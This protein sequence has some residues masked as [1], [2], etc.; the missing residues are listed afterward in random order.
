MSFVFYKKGK[1][2]TKAAFLWKIALWMNF[3][4]SDG[5]QMKKY[6]LKYCC[7]NIV[8]E[9]FLPFIVFQN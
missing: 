2:L 4:L 8:L 5:C 7:R 1:K 9:N 3:Y 6:F